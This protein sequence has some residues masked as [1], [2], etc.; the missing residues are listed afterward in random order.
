MRIRSDRRWR[1]AAPPDAVWAAMAD[2]AAFPGR[3]PW[4]DDFDGRRLAPGEVWSC[5]VRAPVPWAVHFRLTVDEVEDA[6]RVAATLEGD[7]EGTARL[8]LTASSPAGTATDVRLR[9]ALAPDR[10]ALQVAAALARPIVNFG[11]DWVLDTGARQFARD[12]P[13]PLRR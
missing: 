11:H 8:D 5:T 12:L 4:L 1:F 9:A 6:R 10:G 13:A 2:L 7:I 3:W